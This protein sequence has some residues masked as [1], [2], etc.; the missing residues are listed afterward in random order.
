M[1]PRFNTV[2]MTISVMVA[3]VIWAACVSVLIFIHDT[4]E[5]ETVGLSDN[6]QAKSD[7]KSVN[8]LYLGPHIITVCSELTG[9]QQ[10]I[11]CP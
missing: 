4:P 2:A 1:L 5:V 3:L 8:D 6:P 7:V 10:Q 11:G 9:T